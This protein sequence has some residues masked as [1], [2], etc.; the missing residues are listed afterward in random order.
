MDE[1]HRSD[2]DGNQQPAYDMQA[3]PFEPEAAPWWADQPAA[4]AYPTVPAQPRRRFLRVGATGAAVI[5]AAATSGVVVHALDGNATGSTIT[6]TTVPAATAAASVT[7]ALAKAEKSVVI[8]ND[9]ITETSSESGGFGGGF[10]GGTSTASAAGTGIIITAGGEV[11]TNAHVVNGATDIKVT[12]PDGSVHS[13]SIVGLDA[14]K[15]LAVIQVSG[16]SGLTPATWANSA[17]AQ[18]GDSVIAIGNAEGYGGKP[19]VTEGI[20]SA[21]GR[22]LSSSTD[23]NDSEENLSGLLQTDASINPGNSG[24]PLVD[25]AGDVVGIDT[26]VATGTSSEPAQG[27]G[28]AIPSNEV[29]TEIPI[30]EKGG[31]TSSSSSSTGAVLGVVVSDAP[32][33][34]ATVEQVESGSGAAKAGLQAGD[35]IIG[36]GRTEITDASDLSAAVEADSVGQRVR[37]T[38]T[39]NGSTDTTTAT[40]GS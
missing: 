12:L 21:T 10:G 37:I 6:T 23:G 31:G 28:F 38:F 30:L 5:L 15:D 40:L 2:D 18:V 29:V 7:T 14:T 35:V 1:Q 13:A 27:I 36:L 9:T 20:L 19:S 39:R 16:V 25:S 3:L 22:S 4:P 33:G 26:A 11:V 24:G 32:G 34:G 8:I 17:T